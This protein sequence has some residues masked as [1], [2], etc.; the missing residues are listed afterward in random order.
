MRSCDYCGCG[1]PVRPHPNAA[2]MPEGKMLSVFT[3][4]IFPSLQGLRPLRR[5]AAIL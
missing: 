1:N 2:D 3:T 5:Y 4:S